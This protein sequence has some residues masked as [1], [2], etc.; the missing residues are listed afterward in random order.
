MCA[1]FSG[2]PRKLTV[3]PRQLNVD[4]NYVVTPTSLPSIN[5]SGPPPPPYGAISTSATCGFSQA[6]PLPPKGHKVYDI[7]RNLPEASKWL[8]ATN[9][10]VLTQMSTPRLNESTPP[11]QRSGPLSLVDSPHGPSHPYTSPHVYGSYRNLTEA[12]GG[13][14]I[15]NRHQYLRFIANGSPSSAIP[16]PA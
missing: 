8:R 7:Y 2:S 15:A 11:L 12:E 10:Y 5:E 1:V 4:K 14:Q 13:G 6:P 16:F 9:N 3:P